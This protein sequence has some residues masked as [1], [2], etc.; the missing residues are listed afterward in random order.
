MAMAFIKLSSPTRAIRLWSLVGFP[1]DGKS[2]FSAQLEGP[3]LPVNADHRYSEVTHLAGEGNVLGLSD[4]PEDNNDPLAID[5]HLKANMP[6]S[7]VRTIV[8]DSVTP[9][10]QHITR[11]KKVE[12]H[13]GESTAKNKS[14]IHSEKA[15]VMALLGVSIN[16]W[17]TDVLWIWH[18]SEGSYNGQK[19][20]TQSISETERGRLRK[21]LNAE[22]EV[23]MD[24][25]GRRGIHV[26]WCRRTD[27]PLDEVVWDTAENAAAGTYWKGVPE[28]LD[29]LL[30]GKPANIPQPKATAISP[31]KHADPAPAAYAPG[32]RV[33]EGTPALNAG[34]NVPR[35]FAN[36][37]SAI[38]WGAEQ[39][40]LNVSEVTEI[41]NSVKT[42]VQPR[43][44]TDMWA[45]WAAEVDTRAA[46]LV[47]DPEKF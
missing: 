42:K 2:S 10:F 41:Y 32:D 31:A 20:V 27:G 16:K 15:D 34:P 44:A 28:R 46:S 23:V 4:K 35:S 45:A 17:G 37:E 11:L 25:R 6:G 26:M 12:E 21:H 30:A 3:I 8:V 38:A 1:G 7:G 33:P 36:P 22:L 40:Q 43:R 14:S 18:Y 39:L 9:I 47:G 19:R 24:D 13:E 29:A 5:R